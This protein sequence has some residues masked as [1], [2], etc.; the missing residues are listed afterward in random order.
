MTI[1]AV[2]S[3]NYNHN[4]SISIYCTANFFIINCLQNYSKLTIPIVSN[5]LKTSLWQYFNLLKLLLLLIILLADGS[6]A[7]L[8]S[9][10]PGS[11]ARYPKWMH[12]FENQLSLDFRTKQPNALLLYTDDGGIQGNFFSLTITNKKLQLDFRLGDETNY[13]SSERPV[14]TMR[15]NDIEVSDYRWHRLTLFQAWENVKLQLDD[16]VLF[17]ILNQN[18]FVF[19]N[20]KTN[21]DMFIGG[22]PK[23][24]YLLGAM[25][26]PLKRHT[27]SFAG[28]VKNLLY[29]LY[30]QGVT[31]PQI[32]E[33]VG[34]RQSDDDYCK[35]T[36]IASK[37]DYFCR[38]GGICYSTNDGPKCDCSFTDFRGQ[39][40]EQVRFDSHLSFNGRELIGYD[41]SN[42]SAGIIRFRSENITLSFKTTHSRALLYIGGDRLNYIHITLDDGAVVATSK[43]D[44]TEK[45]IIRILN[46]YPS[47]RYNDDRWH[48]VTVFRTLT[49]MTLIV[50]NLNDEIRQY[51][52]EIDWLVNSFAYLGG[53]PKNKNI[54]EIDVENF[55]GCL[56]KVKYEADAYLINFITLADQGYGQSIIRSA[57]ELTF[58]CNKQALYADVFSFNT[59]QHFITLP[60]WNSV[61][62]GSL[63]FQLRTQ[64]FDGLI[65]Y[66][67]SLPT[68]KTGY[69]YFA[70]ELIDGHLFMIINLGSGHIRLQTTAEKITDGAVWHSV[71]LERMGRSGT[72][73][74]DNIKTDFSTPGVSANLII[75]EP[76]Y[77]GAVPWPSNES[78]PVD[79]H[80]P[81]PIWTANLRKGYIGCLKGIRING[82]SPNIANIFQEQQKNFKKGIS[83][84][85]SANVNQDFCALS[86]CKNFGRCENGYNSFRCDC[87]VS[88]ME[89]TLCDK[90]PEYVDFSTNNVPSLLLPKSIESEAET[91]ECKFRSINER[92]VLLDTKSI[93]SP[94]HRILLLLI[95]GELE[96]HLNFENSH[97]V[98]NW[99]INLNDNRIHSM[100]IKRRGEKLLLFLDGKWEHNYF[101][102]SSKLVLDIDEISAGHSLHAMS[103]T[104]FTARANDTLEEKFG[105][106]MIKMLFNDFDILKSVKRRNPINNPSEKMIPSRDR[107]KLKNRKVKSSSVTFEKHNA[108]AMINDKHLMSIKNIYRISF[109]FRTL[110]PSAM[111]FAFLTN[112]TYN[113]D[114]A[115][116]ELHYGRI[117]YTYSFSTR[118]EVIMSPAL[119][120]GQVLN[121]FK[122]HSVIIFQKSLGGEHNVVIDNSSIVMS[123]VR[124]HIVNLHTKLYIGDIPSGIS[125]FLRLKN[126]SGFHGCISSFRIGNEY[127]DILKD[128]IESFG[129]VKGCHGPHT[130]CSPKICLNRG[131]C[132]QK[133]NSTKCDCSMT[134]YA[135]ER[136]D[137]FGTT[138]IFD[139]SLSAIYYEY[140]KSIQPSTNRD[141]MAIG[142][143]TRQAN[144]VLL[145]VQCNVDGDFLTVFLKNAHLHI[146]YNLGSRDHDVG[147]SSALLNDDK[148]HAV[149]IYRQEANLTLY[150]DNREPIYYSPLGGDMELVTLNMQWRIAI[151][152][153]F[154]LL[155]RTKRRKREQIY[156][157]YK[158]FITGVNFNGLMIL[159][160][161][162]QGSQHVYRIGSPRLVHMSS[163]SGSTGR[164]NSFMNNAPAKDTVNDW[165]ATSKE[166]FIEAEGSG[167]VE[168]E[169]QE[170]C[171]ITDLDHTGFITPILP[172]SRITGGSDKS[173][174]STEALITTTAPTLTTTRVKPITS[175]ST[176]I[177]QLGQS[178]NLAQEQQHQPTTTT[179]TTTINGEFTQRTH[180]FL[181]TNLI[182]VITTT[183]TTTT[184]TITTTTTNIAHIST[185]NTT[186]LTTIT[187]TF[188]F[189][190]NYD[191]NY[192]LFTIPK[193][194]SNGNTLPPA[195]F[196]ADNDDND[197]NDDRFAFFWPTISSFRTQTAII[198][199]PEIRNLETS[200]PVPIQIIPT[201]IFHRNDI[202]TKKPFPNFT[203]QKDAKRL[204]ETK[205]K[206]FI[207]ATNNYYLLS[208]IIQNNISHQKYDSN[209][210]D[211]YA[212][213]Y[214]HP[215][216][217]S[218]YNNY[219]YPNEMHKHYAFSNS[220]HTYLQYFNNNSECYNYSKNNANYSKCR[221][222]T[223][224]SNFSAPLSLLP[225]TKL[226][227]LIPSTTPLSL[228]PFT[229]P[230]SLIPSTTPLSLI[231]T[232]TPL[233]LLPSTT[234]LSLQPSTTPLSLLPSAAPLS[235]FSPNTNTK[236]MQIS[237]AVSQQP[238]R[239]YFED[240]WS[241]IAA[242][243][244]L[245]ID[246]GENVSR[247]KT[248][249]T[250]SS[251]I[252][253]T[254]NS[255]L[256]IKSLNFITIDAK[257]STSHQAI[258]VNDMI[259]SR[260]DKNLISVTPKITSLLL[261]A[262]TKSSLVNDNAEERK[263]E[264]KVPE[265]KNLGNIEQQ[266]KSQRLLTVPTVSSSLSSL[267]S[268]LSSTSSSATTT[269]T[270]T[271][272]HRIR[273][274]LV[275]HTIYAVRPTTPM[276]ELITDTAKAPTT[277]T[278]FPRTA[279]ISIASLSVI[280][281]IAIVVFCVFRCRQSGPSTDQYPMVCSS[282][283]S[284]YAPIPAELSPPMMRESS[285]H[286]APPFFH[287]RVNQLDGGY[288][289]IKGAVIPNGN[290]TTNNIKNNC[291]TSINGRKKEFKEWYV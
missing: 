135:G 284:G 257:Q 179:T 62:S 171:Q 216:N 13:L 108:Y 255:N 126:I 230:L 109:K 29:R 213:Y 215:Y 250:I 122:W 21:S 9:G 237:S 286:N 100:R 247:S 249:T 138:Y 25:S 104:H 42:N 44:G 229:T 85:C 119:P 162:A 233:S 124:G 185:I 219:N 45:R 127:L 205:D 34:M 96:L 244:A 67:G 182:T 38:N 266:H 51:A 276:G 22:V 274:T 196:R 180:T 231:P 239:N 128:A 168:F 95:D 70:F 268:S 145:S 80:V 89:G 282:K 170:K 59:G 272:K 114:F 155:H 278:D 66:H 208:S 217:I 176:E 49:L 223:T 120:D 281:I 253:N 131:K 84:G 144:A 58:S 263:K 40:C 137:N 35:I 156:D 48:T 97:H 142:F 163:Y 228:I 2:S 240:L 260:N 221:Y 36:N 165:M 218:K 166:G 136:C 24:T 203:M 71:T 190:R 241:D 132:I 261:N 79:F 248:T 47:G 184:T 236:F 289:P 147:L 8:L 68:T 19:G 111:L 234:L 167:C 41:V 98:F 39:R 5:K 254:I 161:L 181:S 6:N 27:I 57:G 262:S 92:S 271:V 252:T 187:S 83:Y 202:T 197:D 55:Y 235:P 226:L 172:T 11:Y 175:A 129:I 152:A 251:T 141:E 101:L 159:D 103:S 15:L 112:S 150:I 232:A 134:T 78:D 164:K 73:I 280:I 153:S 214:Y 7:I 52:P 10:A 259:T 199:S 1:T 194:N 146:R 201:N 188:S 139:S 76:I 87:S 32:I 256:S 106:Q 90:E 77:L 123:N 4:K 56:K 18:S 12:T 212:R 91:I 169:E 209:H 245:I 99:G 195:L 17:K 186:T 102:P 23:D 116:L 50:D 151:G 191:N 193:I 273:T 204:N 224:T 177:S 14:V 26:S 200:A 88:A 93:K 243:P 75:E 16:T 148:H 173:K 37:N 192:D 160:M 60:K 283:Q 117:R 31:A 61:A 206:K 125:G 149:I 178:E 288:Q 28:G 291:A 279:L 287:N 65:L 86:P 222:A 69:D 285:R 140:P 154:N 81:S 110:S 211:N 269:T 225:S 277:P 72:V 107:Y 115:S 265:A 46:N 189:S 43:F 113:N 82:I 198:S 246:N 53:I 174:L 121:D 74:V 207:T 94:N 30:P 157:S 64:E 130:R 158:G 264:I 133:W 143:R 227:S 220:N 290:N 258:S 20:L 242:P 54:P 118:T 270:T 183:T 238:N 63:S 3:I 33:S 267:S 105:G 210:S 275:S